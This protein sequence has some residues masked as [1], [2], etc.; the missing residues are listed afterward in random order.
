MI[1]QFDDKNLPN[2]LKGK[3]DV[4]CREEKKNK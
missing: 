4:T 1:C 2:S 3:T